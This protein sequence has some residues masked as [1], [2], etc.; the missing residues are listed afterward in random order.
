VFDSVLFISSA[1]L[2][3]VGSL[4]VLFIKENLMHACVSLLTA[5]FG[6]AGLYATLGAD[7]LAAT[8]LVV[9]VGGVVILMLFGIMLTGGGTSNENKFGIEKVPGMGSVK[10]YI[11]AGVNVL[12]ISLIVIRIMAN[13][14]KDYKAVPLPPY[15]STVEKL[16]TLLVTDHVLAFEISSILLLGA[17]VGAAI[18]ARPTRRTN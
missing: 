2:V 16:G 11:V 6:V 7:F 12:V 13:V 1:V 5:L 10:T 8:Q 15:E 4:G 18:I 14:M 9:Y 17:L 3:L